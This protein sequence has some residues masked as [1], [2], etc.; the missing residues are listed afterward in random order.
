MG[1]NESAV[2]GKAEKVPMNVFREGI[3]IDQTLNSLYSYNH[4]RFFLLPLLLLVM[5]VEGG[6]RRGRVVWLLG[7]DHPQDASVFDVNG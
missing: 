4:Y 1:G 2:V 5:L 6:G 7:D 3:G